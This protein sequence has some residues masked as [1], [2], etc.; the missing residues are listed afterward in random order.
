MTLYALAAR[1]S[2][3]DTAFTRRLRR[4]RL[5]PCSPFTPHRHPG[6]VHRYNLKEGRPQ[7]LVLGRHVPLRPASFVAIGRDFQR[8]VAVE[9]PMV[10]LFQ[11]SLERVRRLEDNVTLHRASTA[12]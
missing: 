12:S 8:V 7:I 6:R 3:G 1:V 4:T 11:V 2:P 9:L 5:L 10:L